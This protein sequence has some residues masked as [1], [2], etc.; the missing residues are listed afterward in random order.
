[1]IKGIEPVRTRGMP[2]GVNF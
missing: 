1:M 2:G